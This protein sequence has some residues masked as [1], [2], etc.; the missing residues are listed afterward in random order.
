MSFHICDLNN[1]EMPNH[2]YFAMNADS[3]PVC[4]AVLSPRQR[5]CTGKPSSPWP[6][7]PA[8]WDPKI[9]FWFTSQL[10]TPCS[11]LFKQPTLTGRACAGFPQIFAQWWPHLCKLFK[12]YLLIDLRKREKHQFAVPLI[13]TLIGWFLYVPWPGIKPATL[14]YRGEVAPFLIS[15]PEAHRMRSGPS[16][17]TWT[18]VTSMHIRPMLLLMLPGPAWSSVNNLETPNSNLASKVVMKAWFLSE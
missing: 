15:Y 1:W 6:Q 7:G 14:A 9:P 18:H 2:M 4:S 3:S 17:D 5:A 16:T 8:H 12:K 11:S 10:L 13:Y